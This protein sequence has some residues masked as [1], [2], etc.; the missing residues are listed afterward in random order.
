MLC[1]SDYEIC[2]SMTKCVCFIVPVHV[3]FS[4]K[5]CLFLALDCGAADIA[6]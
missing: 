2:D 3:K 1:E 6:I 4:Y 5:V